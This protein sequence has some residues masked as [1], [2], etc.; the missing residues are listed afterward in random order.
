M[1][2]R[3]LGCHGGASIRHRNVTFVIDDRVALDAGSLAGALTVDEQVAIETVLVTHSHLD[4]VGDL[5]TFCDTRAQMAADELLIAGLGETIEAL[6]AHFFNDVLWPDFQKISLGDRFTVRLQRLVPEERVE[7]SGLRVTPI[8]VNHTVPSCG[9]LVSDG[10]GT[11]AY[12]GDTGP[13]DRFWQAVGEERDVRALIT[14][15]SF[16]DRMTELAT[17]S[18]HLTPTL[19]G[20]ELEKLAGADDVPTWIYG[21]KPAFVD[22]IEAELGAMGRTNLRVL[23]GVGEL[24]V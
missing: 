22:E 20:A 23:S 24:R 10:A 6:Q 17:A 13:T 16:P 15:V 5:G 7:L 14:E 2:V 8:E 4:H 12:S 19:L 3:I 9:F 18:G 11:L 21:M 1:K